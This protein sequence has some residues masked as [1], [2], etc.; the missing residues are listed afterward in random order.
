MVHSDFIR[1]T[2]GDLTA[3]MQL[4]AVAFPADRRESRRTLLRSLHSPHQEVW[5]IGDPA[6]AQVQAAMILRIHRLRLR[7][8]SIAVDPCFQGCGLGNRLLLHARQ[9][10]L[11]LGRSLLSLEADSSQPRLL[12]W[13]QRHGFIKTAFLRHYYSR[14]KHAWRMLYTIH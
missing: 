3:L 10:A 13:Y 4:E 11:D 5:I 7:I 2:A 1:A 8:Q 14:G 6:D 12:E 9:R